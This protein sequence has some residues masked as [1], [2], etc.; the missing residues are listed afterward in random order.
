MSFYILPL[1]VPLS[2]LGVSFSCYTDDTQ[3]YIPCTS[4]DFLINIEFLHTIHLT[5]SNWLSDNFLKLNHS[6]TEVTLIGT[7]KSVAKCKNLSGSITLGT[8]DFDWLPTVKNL[9]VLF[10]ESLSFLPHIKNCR[11]NCF[12]LLRNVSHLRSYFDRPSFE[13]IINSLITSKL[14][15]CNSLFSRLPVN[16]ISLLQSIQNYAA[17]LILKR[18]RYTSITPLLIELHWLPIS[19]RI[20]FKTLLITYK[21][22]HHSTPSYLASKIKLRS[23][24]RP[25]RNHDNLLLEIPRSNSARMGDRAFSTCAPKLWNSLPFHI[26]N[27]P[28]V[29]IFK[30]SLKTHLFSL[31]FSH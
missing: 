12:F 6:K 20:N 8:S 17:R 11:K 26:R 7:P 23:P 3:L 28:S 27:S 9:G 21:L 10:D 5:I 18:Q 13:I 15:Y 2:S 30:K 14:D 31:R 16:S 25:L 19:D 22:V 1:L 4:S 29:S 24:T